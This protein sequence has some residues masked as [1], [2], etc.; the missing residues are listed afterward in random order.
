MT[1]AQ[2]D[3]PLTRIRIEPAADN[4]LKEPS[5]VMIDKITTTRRAKVHDRLGSLAHEE[6]VRVERSILVFLG[7]AG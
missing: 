5:H 3:A 1:T 2:V 4:G 6:M 7:I